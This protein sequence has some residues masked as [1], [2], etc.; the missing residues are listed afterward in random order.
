MLTDE[1][2]HKIAE[3]IVSKVNEKKC[4]FF[5]E[6]D[7]KNLAEMSRFFTKGKNAGI[8]FIISS[9]YIVLGFL[10]LYGFK[11]WIKEL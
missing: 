9:F 6:E 8:S 3:V 10:I 4:L 1:D 5:S 2:I 11:Y 7:A